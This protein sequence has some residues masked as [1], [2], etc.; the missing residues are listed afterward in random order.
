M[1]DSYSVDSGDVTIKL[2]GVDE[3][4]EEVGDMGLD[5]VSKECQ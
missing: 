4:V 5:F 2:E 1:G 3:I